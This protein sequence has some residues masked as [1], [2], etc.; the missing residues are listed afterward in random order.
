M[1][2]KTYMEVKGTKII[3][4]RMEGG[5]G[6]IQ[7]RFIYYMGNAIIFLSIDYAILK[8]QILTLKHTL[9]QNKKV[10]KP[11]IKMK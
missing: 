9:K 2:F 7:L 11:I 3:P 1:Q 5:N 4:Q 10:N 6:S 8:M